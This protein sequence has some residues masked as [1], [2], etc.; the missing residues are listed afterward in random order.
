MITA[1]PAP[2]PLTFAPDLAVGD[3]QRAVRQRRHIVLDDGLRGGDVP[4]RQHQPPQHR[5]LQSLQV[6]RHAKVAGPR[7]AGRR[8][9]QRAELRRRLRRG[10]PA[11]HELRLQ[12]TPG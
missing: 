6:A 12:P 9:A 5:C 7:L 8:K 11:R 2:R 1:R 10:A 4:R 3:A